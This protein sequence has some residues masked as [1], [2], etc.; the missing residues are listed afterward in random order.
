MPPI[1]AY[2][3]IAD[4]VG[5]AFA[6]AHQP[7]RADELIAVA[8]RRSGLTDFGETP[9]QAPLR[10]LL[11]ACSEEANLSLIGRIVTRWDVVRFLSNLLRLLEEETRSPAYW[12]SRS[13]NRFSSPGCPLRHD[14]S[15]QLLAEDPV[16]LVPRVWQLI[17]PYP[18]RNAGL[19]LTSGR[20][21]ARQLRLFGLL[22]PDFR[23]MHPIDAYSPQECPKSQRIYSPACASTRLIVPSYRHW[24]DETGHSRPIAFTGAFCSTS[25]IRHRLADA[26]C[27]NVRTMCSPLTR[28]GRFI[29]TLAW[30]LFTGT[31]RG[32]AVGC[33][34]DRDLRRPFTRSIDKVEIGR[35]D[36]TAG[37]RRPN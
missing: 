33:P 7:M 32:P 11:R 37:S 26:G 4:I 29:R 10:K 21:V 20:S 12:L 19:S 18:P 28:S 22:A 8:H 25:S 3:Q 24:L 16:N 14:V 6:S 15:A 31:A 13:R 30:S 34:F 35:R 1:S 23:R 9:F 27:S 17:Q 2:F 5:D 36:T